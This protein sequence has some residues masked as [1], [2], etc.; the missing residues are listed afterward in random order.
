MEAEELGKGALVRA[1]VDKNGSKEALCRFIG[2]K[3][4]G[5]GIRVDP[6]GENG[7]SGGD[8]GM[9]IGGRADADG[10]NRSHATNGGNGGNGGDGGSGGNGDNGGGG[11]GNSVIGDCGVFSFVCAKERVC[12]AFV[13]V[14]V[15]QRYNAA[16]GVCHM[17]LC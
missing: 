10:G 9:D 14:F 13:A 6:I 1:T 4:G 7:G 3:G 5:G 16:L 17:E 11:N 2:C 12:G 15:R 8:G